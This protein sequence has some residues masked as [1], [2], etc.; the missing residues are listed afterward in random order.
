[1]HKAGTSDGKAGKLTEE[2]NESIEAVTDEIARSLEAVMLSTHIK[3]D[4][5]REIVKGVA[6]FWMDLC[7]QRCR[8]MVVMPPSA[9]N[10]LGQVGERKT[11]QLIVQP[12]IE[13]QGNSQGEQLDNVKEVLKGCDEVKSD[14]NPRKT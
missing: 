13:R 2:M 4:A 11:Q 5:I 9:K 8:F 1:M 14:F 10:L 12:K 3:T 7:S 6:Q